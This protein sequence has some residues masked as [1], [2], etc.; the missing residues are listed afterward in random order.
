VMP[1]FLAGVMNLANPKFMSPLW[2]DPIGVAIIKYT[3]G[4]MLIGILIMRKIIRIR[5]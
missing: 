1:F 4:L 2:H 5:Y 3:L